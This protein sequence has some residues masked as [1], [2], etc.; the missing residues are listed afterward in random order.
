MHWVSYLENPQSVTSIFDEACDFSSVELHEAVLS[1]DGP[2]LRLR[3]DVPI[4]PMLSNRKWPEGANTTQFVMA[5]WGIDTLRIHG[6]TSQISG[7][8]SVSG[9]E[10]SLHLTF[11]APDCRIEHRSA[12]CA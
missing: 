1:R 4:L 3:F 10:G 7:Q 9:D 12:R 6:W 2:V 11:A 8:L 5:A